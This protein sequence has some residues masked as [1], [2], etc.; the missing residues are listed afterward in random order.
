[1]MRMR[2]TLIMMMMMMMNGIIKMMM[3]CWSGGGGVGPREAA[4]LPQGR[5]LRYGR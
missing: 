3:M 5:L 4:V 1:M 2:M